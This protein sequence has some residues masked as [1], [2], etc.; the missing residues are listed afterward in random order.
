MS[1]TYPIL[2][3]L[4]QGSHQEGSMKL[5]HLGAGYDQWLQSKFN[6]SQ[7]CAIAAGATSDGFT[8]VK[9]PPGTGKVGTST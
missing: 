5:E 6:R 8:L 4:L 2:P 1:P 3:R 7:Q 9:G